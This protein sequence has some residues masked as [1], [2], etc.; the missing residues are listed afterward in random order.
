MYASRSKGS[1]TGAHGGL[2]RGGRALLRRAEVG[3][4][5][6][7]AALE[8]LTARSAIASS[9]NAMRIRSHMGK[10]AVIA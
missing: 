5:D 8:L 9:S 3:T 1:D 10:S 2:A 4:P 6:T 7:D